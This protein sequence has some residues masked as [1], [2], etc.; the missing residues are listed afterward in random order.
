[1]ETSADT[2]SAEG[3]CL[4]GAVRYRLHGEPLASSICH[5]Q[6]CRR[7]SAAPSVGWVTVNRANFMLLGASAR[8]YES[9]PGVT[10]SFCATCGTPLTYSRAD[11]P[12]TVDVTTVSLDDPN[13]FRP[14]REVWLD[15]QLAWEA[16]NHTLG[17]YGRG[18]SEGPKAET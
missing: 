4:C 6:S 7:A 18:A 5:C 1:M 2:P 11:E 14:T 8:E 3:G 16:T 13:R 10:R 15:D 12:M 9:S 17:H